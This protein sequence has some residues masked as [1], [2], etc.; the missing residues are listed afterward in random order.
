MGEP[1]AGEPHDNYTYDTVA[2][3][4]ES[5]NVYVKALRTYEQRLVQTVRNVRAAAPDLLSS[6]AAERLPA[7]REAE[8]VKRVLQFLHG[9]MQ[10]ARVGRSNPPP[11]VF[12]AL[13]HGTVR[14]IKAVVL[15]HVADLKDR[16]DALKRGGNIPAGVLEAAEASVANV[17][18]SVSGGVFAN[19]SAAPLVEP[20]FG[21]R[22]SDA[23][24]TA[25]GHGDDEPERVSASLEPKVGRLAAGAVSPAPERA[26]LELSKE[27]RL[28]W[29]PVRSVLG[30]R[31]FAAIKE[32]VGLAGLDI[33]NLGHLD[34]AAGA[35][36]P[37]LLSA[38][39]ALIGHYDQSQLKR[40]LEITIE[41]LA[42]IDQTD[43]LQ[44]TLN[45]LGWTVHEGAVIPLELL[46]TGELPELPAESHAD[47][48]KAATR[49]RDGD[50]SGTMTSA[51]SA[52][53]AAAASVL[54]AEDIGD[55]GKASFQEKV[56]RALA[57]RNVYAK[58]EADLTSIGWE[59]HE[60]KVLVENL[61]KSINSAAYVMQSLRSRMGDVHG[62][63]P[64]LR[65][66]VFDSLKWASVIVRLLGR[67][68]SQ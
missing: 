36:K 35:S 38:I 50:L 56:S 22:S 61:R 14:L 47:L 45:R 28:A 37:Q 41:E 49:L 16:R 52:V 42:R 17:E 7:S 33:L 48:L 55:P 39:D 13:D 43:R 62:T 53:E 59:A 2:F 31:S 32:I 30:D 1:R 4:T 24:A 44:Y 20:R 21:S 58:L 40:F 60:V 57:G 23:L 29:G 9:K 65:P 10:G 63:K 15:E 46:D 54:I 66:L 26:M 27:L 64:G 8:M 18:N 5:L 25:M 19:A 12:I 11:F 3:R 34:Q 68:T 51:C 67:E 6:E